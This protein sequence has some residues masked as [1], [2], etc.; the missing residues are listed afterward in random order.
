MKADIYGYLESKQSP[1]AAYV[2]DIYAAANKFRIDP[3]LIVAIAGAESSF[4]KYLSGSYNAW[5]IGP[6]RSYGSWREGIHAAAKLLREGYVGQGLNTLRKIQAKWAPLGASNDPTN[7]NSAWLRNTSSFY[8]ELGG[9]P[10]AASKEWR[11]AASPKTPENKQFIET[12]SLPSLPALRIPDTLAFDPSNPSLI[13]VG[14]G[15]SSAT[16]LL[17]ALVNQETAPQPRRV[18]SQ[19]AAPVSKPA[20]AAGPAVKGGQLQTMNRLNPKMQQL[21]AQFGLDITSGYRSIAEQTAIYNQGGVAAKPGSSYHNFGRAIDVAVNDASMRFVEYARK[22][23]QLFREV[24]F[25][26]G[27]HAIYIKNG[28]LYPGRKLGGHDDHV[29]IAR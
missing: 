21:A 2:D 13:D 7:L 24:F 9:N 19:G 20:A 28:V 15:R 17:S 14:L 26:V 27:K 22:H 6:G 3:K 1:L 18:A 23:P 8:E 4:G 25:D 11:K 16:S 5:G 12:P 29:H 10:N